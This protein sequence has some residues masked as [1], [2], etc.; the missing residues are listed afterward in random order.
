M[1]HEEW[2]KLLGEQWS[3]CDNIGRHRLFLK[4]IIGTSKPIP[5]MMNRK[6]Q[7]AF[8]KLPDTLTIYRGCSQK[9]MIG[10]SY[11]TERTVAEKFPFYARYHADEPLQKRYIKRYKYTFKYTVKNNTIQIQ[12]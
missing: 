9:N 11:A 5:E 4:D 2:L 7:A 3:G 8:D 10:V 6:E 12:I 1:Q